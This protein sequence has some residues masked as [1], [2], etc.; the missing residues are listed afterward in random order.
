LSGVRSS[1]LHA[2]EEGAL[3]VARRLRPHL[4]DQQLL[5]AD[6]DELL[7]TVVLALQVH[8]EAR[9]VLDVALQPLVLVLEL[10]EQAL[11]RPARLL[12]LAPE[13]AD[14]VGALPD[15]GLGEVALAIFSKRASGAGWGA[16]R[17]PAAGP[18]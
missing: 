2:G 15:E 3:G 13:I 4:G 16:S 14:L 9:L 6:G 18:G 12:E 5:G 8:R 7:E 10:L 17:A 1:W 11:Q